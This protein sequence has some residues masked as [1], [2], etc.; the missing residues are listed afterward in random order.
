MSNKQITM[1]NQKG[2]PHASKIKRCKTIATRYNL[3]A[4]PI[5]LEIK[6]IAAAVMA[7]F[8]KC[9]IYHFINRY[10]VHFIIKWQ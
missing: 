10:Q 3:N 7:H 8:S 2:T 9:S 5:V 1:V 4:E 6:N